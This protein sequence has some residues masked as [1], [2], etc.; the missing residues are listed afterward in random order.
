MWVVWPAMGWGVGI[1]SHGIR[2]FELLSL[3]RP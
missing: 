2:Y 1:I 3:F